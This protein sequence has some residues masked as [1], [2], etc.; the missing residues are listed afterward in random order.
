M[1]LFQN[2]F[3]TSI[4]SIWSRTRHSI[5][6]WYHADITLV[7]S[8]KIDF[9]LFLFPPVVNVAHTNNNNVIAKAV[10]YIVATW[11]KF[12]WKKGGPEW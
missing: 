6:D 3:K 8:D 2:N 12:R 11:P 9:S 4:T 10:L 7:C 5:N 1:Q